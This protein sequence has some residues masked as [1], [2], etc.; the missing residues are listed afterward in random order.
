MDLTEDEVREILELI[1]KSHFDFFELELGEL[2]LTVSKGPY[3]PRETATLAAPPNPPSVSAQ[4]IEPPAPESIE[5][6]PETPVAP[7]GLEPIPAPMVGTFYAAP[8]PGAPPFV[9]QGSNVTPE[10]T[11]GL[12]EVM[13]VFTGVT[14]RVGGMIE[15]IL[16]SDSEFVEF[17]QVLFLVR[18]NENGESEATTG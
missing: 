6:A 16:V 7:D 14:A 12:I 3:V 17:G 15:E 18:P 4:P 9:E 13:K 10:T 11:V 1:D 5:G 8:K 2:R